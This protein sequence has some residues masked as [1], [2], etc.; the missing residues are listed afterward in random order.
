MGDLVERLRDKAAEY[1][2]GGVSVEVWGLLDE[3][4]DTLERLQGR[5][6]ARE[7]ARRVTGGRGADG[8]E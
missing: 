7:N 8:Q 6:A 3:A 4:A 1:R 5:N 2:R